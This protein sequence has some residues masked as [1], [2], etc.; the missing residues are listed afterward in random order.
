MP[1]NFSIAN[2][3]S[4][5]Y[6][7]YIISYTKE[8]LKKNNYFTGLLSLTRLLS[9]NVLHKDMI[10]AIGAICP[11]LN[12]VSFCEEEFIIMWSTGSDWDGCNYSNRKIENR[13]D[14]ENL[15]TIFRGWPKV[16]YIFT[17][18]TLLQIKCVNIIF[19]YVKGYKCHFDENIPKICKGDSE[20][21]RSKFATPSFRFLQRH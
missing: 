10:R 17:F 19:L 13:I 9:A 12:E 11:L 4:S 2:N 20:S 21:I 7:Y 6:Q 15:I 18:Q 3:D 14:P 16:S 5:I 1:S 8:L